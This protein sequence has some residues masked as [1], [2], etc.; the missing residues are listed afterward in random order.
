MKPALALAYSCGSGYTGHCYSVAQW[1]GDTFGLYTQITASPLNNM[2]STNSG[3]PDRL[4]SEAWLEDAHTS[5]CQQ[6]PVGQCWVEAGLTV[7]NIGDG[8]ASSAQYFW[9]D[10]RPGYG[11]NEH[12]W[13]AVN[14]NDTVASALIEYSSTDTFY[15]RMLS[16]SFNSDAYGP[17]YSTNNSMSPDW[18]HAGQEVSGT[19]GSSS[20]TYSFTDN[21][22]EDSNFNLHYQTNDGWTPRT[23]D[24]PYGYWGSRPSQSSTGGAWNA[25]C[26]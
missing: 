1:Y 17:S 7:G 23:D 22:W 10:L 15:V 24:P 6:N 18:I 25:Y 12:D 8:Y 26:C 9:A 13:P 14:G 4:Q 11:I 16:S 2:Y 3:T 19:G 21:Q 20:G 5:T